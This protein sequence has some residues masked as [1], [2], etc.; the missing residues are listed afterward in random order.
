[1]TAVARDRHV[2]QKTLDADTI[3]ADGKTRAPS[4][5]PSTRFLL[6]VIAQCLYASKSE[7]MESKG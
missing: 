1:M 3:A 6:F 2:G 4:F 7:I 5:T